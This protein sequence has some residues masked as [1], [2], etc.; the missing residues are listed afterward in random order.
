[1]MNG[2]LRLKFS[3]ATGRVM[4]RVL[5][6][7]VNT[8]HIFTDDSDYSAVRKGDPTHDDANSSLKGW[9]LA[10][11]RAHDVIQEVTERKFTKT[12]HIYPDT[13]FVLGFGQVAIT[14]P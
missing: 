11:Q 8:K 14:C 3:S 4:N 1:M 5:S 10:T 6:Y 12:L 2:L 7:A 9:K 13:D